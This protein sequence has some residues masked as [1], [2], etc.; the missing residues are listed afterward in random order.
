MTLLDTLENVSNT[1][2]HF[3]TGADRPDEGRLG[4]AGGSHE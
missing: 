2:D 1:P 3:A 4:D